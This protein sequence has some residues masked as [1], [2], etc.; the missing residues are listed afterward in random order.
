[1]RAVMAV[2]LILFAPAV[3]AGELRITVEGIRSTIS[4]IFKL[5]LNQLTKI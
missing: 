3:T 1:M 4:S 2:L 5:H